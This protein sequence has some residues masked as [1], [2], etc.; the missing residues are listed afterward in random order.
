MLG[1]NDGWMQGRM[2]TLIAR[3]N[4]EV[5]NL[6]LKKEQFLLEQVAKKR[7]YEKHKA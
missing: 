6:M 2:K 1:H 4:P 7:V 5:H 3:N